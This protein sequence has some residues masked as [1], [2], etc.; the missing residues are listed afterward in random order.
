MNERLEAIEKFEAYLKRR[1]PESRT[2]IDYVS[3]IRQFALSCP[4]AWAEVSLHDIDAFIEQQRQAGLSPATL[5]RRLYAL[6]V[7]FD[8]LAEENDDFSRPNPVR[9]KRHRIKQPKH[10]PRDLSDEQVSQL[11]AVISQPRDRAWFA[12]MLRAGLRVAEVASLTLGAVLRPAQAGQPA[13]LR[14]QGKGQKERLVLLTADAAAVV[15]SW[16]ELRPSTDHELLF[17]NER[18]QP[19]SA[20]GIEWLLRGYSQTAGVKATPHQLR[21]TY[22]RQLLEGGMPLVSL[23]KLLGHSQVTTTQIYT[24]GADPELAQAYQQAMQQF[25]TRP[26][27]PPPPEPVA[28]VGA[29]PTS[30]P[31]GP[32]RPGR[33]MDWEAWAPELPA[34]LRQPSLAFVQGR[35]P[36]WKPQRQRLNAHKSLNY[37]HRFWRWQLSQRPINQPAELRRADLQAFQQAQ[38]AAGAKPASINRHLDD[39]VALLRDLVE[40]GQALDPAL[41]RL[42]PLA[43]PERLPRYLPESQIQQLESYVQQRLSSP[44]PL[45]QLENTCFFLLAHTGIRASECVDLQ[46]QDLDLPGRRLLIRQGKGQRDRVVYLS[47]T[48]CQALLIYTRAVPPMTNVPLLRRPT[49]QPLTYSWLRLHLAEL[50][51]ALEISVTPHQLRHTLAT[52]LINLGVKETRIQKLLGHEHLSTTMIYARLLDPTVEADYLQ[53]MATIEAQQLPLS[54]RPELVP[55]WP[56]PELVEPVQPMQP[57]QASW[58]NSV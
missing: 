29:D 50:G 24:A 15:Q 58:S 56:V 40:Q 55:N 46:G 47:Q 38:L 31:P 8:F 35:W 25:N 17:V 45:V 57:V 44:E 30:L 6:K 26:V 21:H 7:F 2:W 28:Q 48:L 52:R 49:G 51:R 16:L 20:N 32:G 3:D 37:F 54:A 11:W 13:R 43:Q 9:S 42:K 33:P 34:G 36:L 1:A 53:A 10:L 19:L 41:F 23:S 5:K 27:P 4:K 12:L 14:V 18:G 39:I 22:A